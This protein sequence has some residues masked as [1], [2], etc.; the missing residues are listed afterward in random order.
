M[1]NEFP[2]QMHDQDQASQ[3]LDPTGDYVE[4]NTYHI[5]LESGHTPIT[6]VGGGEPLG[7]DI[8]PVN[9]DQLP[10]QYTPKWN[11]EAAPQ[12]PR[13]AGEALSHGDTR[14]VGN[15]VIH[16]AAG[17]NK[18]TSLLAFSEQQRRLRQR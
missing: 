17:Q 6:I 15:S 12:P 14:R 3:Q 13:V 11:F 1:T 9:M 10:K 4:G 5:T 7:P 18:E 16:V 8:N 2:P